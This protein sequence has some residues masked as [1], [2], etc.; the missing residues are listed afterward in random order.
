LG[1]LALVNLYKKLSIDREKHY[2]LLL[3]LKDANFAVARNFQP[4]FPIRSTTSKNHGS[5]STFQMLAS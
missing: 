4:K 5:D 1:P 3:V 2:S